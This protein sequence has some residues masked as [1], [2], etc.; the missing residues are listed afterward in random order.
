MTIKV[1]RDRHPDN[2]GGDVVVEAFGR[3]V[4]VALYVGTPPGSHIGIWR[5]S[6]GELKGLNVRVGRRYVGPCVTAFVHIHRSWT[7]V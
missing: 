5:T 7:R 1:S 3:W 6:W 2:R 4:R